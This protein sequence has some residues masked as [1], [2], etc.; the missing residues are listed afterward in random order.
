[1]ATNQNQV[2]DALIEAGCLPSEAIEESRRMIDEAKLLPKGE[3][4]YWCNR[5]TG[6]CI[7]LKKV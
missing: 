5:E 1:M 6:K 2:I 7:G 4:R 3:I